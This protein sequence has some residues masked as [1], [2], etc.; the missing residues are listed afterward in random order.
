MCTMSYIK[1]MLVFNQIQLKI[2]D[3]TIKQFG[4]DSKMQFNVFPHSQR[5]DMA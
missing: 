2:C 5:S 4:T 3:D 1:H